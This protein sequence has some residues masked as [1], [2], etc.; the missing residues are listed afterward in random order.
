MRYLLLILTSILLST[1]AFATASGK[2][3][4]WVYW[5]FQGSGPKCLADLTLEETEGRL[6]R[7]GGFVDCDIVTME[8]NE[9]VLTKAEG[10]LFID[11]KEVGTYS[12]NSFQWTERYSEEVV[13][14]NTIT[15]NGTNM[16]Y[17]EKWIQ[18]DGRELYDLQGRFF[19]K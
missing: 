2:W 19:K 4:G 18:A 14:E 6:H 15:V 12:Q 17:H 9:E 11:G 3:T 7:V 13:I 5:T 10:K 1:S 16:D 8:I